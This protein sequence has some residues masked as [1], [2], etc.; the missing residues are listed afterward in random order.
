MPHVFPT[1]IRPN[2]GRAARRRAAVACFVLGF[3]FAAAPTA[4]AA[5]ALSPLTRPGCPGRQMVPASAIWWAAMHA[6]K[7]YG[8]GIRCNPSAPY[9]PV[10]NP[11]RSQLMAANPNV[12]YHPIFN[13]VVFRCGCR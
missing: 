13:P 1:T 9:N 12:P 8:Y 11:Y 7:V 6:S 3:V 5:P 2:L 4:F 10:S